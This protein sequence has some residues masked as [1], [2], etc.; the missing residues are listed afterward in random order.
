VR[1]A[2]ANA[3]A[4]LRPLRLRDWL[5]HALTIAEYGRSR[6]MLTLAVAR[7]LPATEA[8]RLLIE[9][10][11]QMPGHVALGL[12]ECGGAA[13]A[14]FLRARQ[15]ATKSWVKKEIDRAIKMIEKRVR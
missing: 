11:D 3:F 13:E 15:P 12:A 7:T 1:W 2:I 9:V 14:A 10:F 4:E 6:E 8:C 5:G